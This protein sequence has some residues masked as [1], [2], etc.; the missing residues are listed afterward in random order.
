MP[1]VREQIARLDNRQAPAA[2]SPDNDAIAGMVASLAARLDA[3]GGSPDEWARLIR[4][5]AVLGQRDKATAVALKA[6]RALAGN[7]AGLQ[8]IETTTREL[9]LTDAT[10]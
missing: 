10:P 9:Q 2:P 1:L 8:T 5:Y 3:Q 4:S 7:T 6:R